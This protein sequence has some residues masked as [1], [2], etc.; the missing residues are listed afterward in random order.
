MANP[1]RYQQRGQEREPQRTALSPTPPAPLPFQ[2]QPQAQPKRGGLVVWEV[3][4]PG[5]VFSGGKLIGPGELLELS[6]ADAARL[7]VGTVKPA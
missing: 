6:E 5:S 3:V 2:P 7:P 1:N 4:G